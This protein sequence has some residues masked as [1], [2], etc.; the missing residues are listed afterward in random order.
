MANNDAATIRLGVAGAGIA[1]RDLHWPALQALG[2]RF[3]IVALAASS[4]K[5]LQ[6]TGKLVGCDNFYNDYKQMIDQERDNLDAV[7]ISLPIGML[8]EGAEY[9]AR[10]GLDVLCEKPVGQNLEEGKRFIALTE[11]YDVSIQ[12]LENFRYRDDLRRTREMLDKGAIGRPY[13]IRVQSVSHNEPDSGGFA[14]TEWRQEGA[15]RGGPL[16]DNGVHHMAAF[17]VLGGPVARV[18]GA[19][20]SASDDYDGVDNAIFALEFESGLIGQYAFSYTAFEEEGE[21]GF[22]EARIYGSTGTLVITD[23]HIRHL[24]ADGEEPEQTFPNHDGGYYNEF[25]DFSEHKR[26]GRPL[27]VT[28]REAFADLHLVL[29]GLDAAREGRV[30][31]VHAGAHGG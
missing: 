11:Q 18:S 15:H 25:L 21:R 3:R 24:T 27:R 13:M 8:Y 22:F 26:T 31:P 1:V 10:A 2:D 20:A 6:E 23:G 16:L 14:G 19:V 5:T 30:L 28:P 17:H 12:I 29:S 7:L 9:A 4:D